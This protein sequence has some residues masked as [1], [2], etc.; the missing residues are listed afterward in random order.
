MMISLWTDDEIALLYTEMTNNEIAERINRTVTA[1]KKKRYEETGHYVEAGKQKESD[2]IQKRIV[3]HMDEAYK[4]ARIITLCER[5]KVK[6]Y[7]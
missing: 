6:L 4:K 2:Y 3:P 1:V 5:L 7:G